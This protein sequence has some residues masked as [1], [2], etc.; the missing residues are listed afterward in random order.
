M[1][2]GYSGHGTHPN[3]L[4][5]R[6]LL[7]GVSL[8][9]TAQ[10]LTA[11]LDLQMVRLIR[12]AINLPQAGAGPK[13]QFS[14]S[15]SRP[16]GEGTVSHACGPVT[17]QRLRPEP[18]A[19]AVIHKTFEIHPPAL[20]HE[21]P[22]AAQALYGPLPAPWQTVMAHGLPAE[23]SAPPAIVKFLPRAV[24]ITGSGRMLDQFA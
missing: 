4:A 14:G 5:R 20:A 13:L 8:E 15:E 2:R 9:T 12:G 18:D 11:A 10:L 21:A 16:G 6:L 19:P 3:G 1:S 7:T 22:R 17:V 23:P 24:D